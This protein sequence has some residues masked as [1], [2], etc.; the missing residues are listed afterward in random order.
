MSIL[1]FSAKIF[2]LSEILGLYKREV[3]Q[4]I[5]FKKT[6]LCPTWL[7]VTHQLM[8]RFVFLALSPTF[9]SLFKFTKCWALNNILILYL[10][11][12]MYI[13]ILYFVE[14]FIYSVWHSTSSGS[15]TI[16]ICHLTA[17]PHTNTKTPPLSLCIFSFHLHSWFSYYS[18]VA[19]VTTK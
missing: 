19:Y 11:L 4:F 5:M 17:D 14:Q 3:I 8:F 6:Q 1:T 12:F 18:F 16:C 2:G 13:L 9:Y 10:I 15:W 7:G